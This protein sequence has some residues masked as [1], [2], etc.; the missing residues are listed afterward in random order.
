M[1]QQIV[2]QP[3]IIRVLCFEK[4]KIILNIAVSHISFDSWLYW[5]T[6]AILTYNNYRR[7]RSNLPLIVDDEADC[8][9]G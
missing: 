4:F 3:C 6:G 7:L 1:C 5:H 2:D 8:F 9:G